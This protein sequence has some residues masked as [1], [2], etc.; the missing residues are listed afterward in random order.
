[1]WAQNDLNIFSRVIV[2]SAEACDRSLVSAAL[3]C[4]DLQRMSPGDACQREAT[5]P[6]DFGTQ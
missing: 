2:M 6:S 4:K 3:G 5:I 1:L